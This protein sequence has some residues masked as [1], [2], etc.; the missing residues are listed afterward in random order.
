[1]ALLIPDDT[2]ANWVVLVTVFKLSRTIDI[3]IDNYAGFDIET[4]CESLS[5]SS[6]RRAAICSLMPF[7]G[8]S[9]LDLGRSLMNGL[10]F[11]AARR[12]IWRVSKPRRWWSH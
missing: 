9:S 6:Y 7:L 4:A 2:G 12:P 10:F 1:M 11:V 3:A 5:Y 8:V